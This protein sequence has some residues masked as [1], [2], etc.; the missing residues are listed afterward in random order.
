MTFPQKNIFGN[1][2]GWKDKGEVA[3]FGQIENGKAVDTVKVCNHCKHTA[4]VGIEDGEAFLFC[5][6]CEQKL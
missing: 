2:K 1:P 3:S 6:V 5:D 4:H